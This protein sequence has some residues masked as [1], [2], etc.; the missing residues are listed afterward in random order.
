MAKKNKLVIL[1]TGVVFEYLKGNEKVR[2]EIFEAIGVENAFVSTISILETYYGM[3]KKEQKDTKSFFQQINHFSID[4]ETCQEAI[5]LMLEY[6]N[7]KIGLPD[8][9]IAA[10][11]LTNQAQLFTYN[12]Q[13]FNYIKGLTLYK[14]KN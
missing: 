1:D 4:K 3:L 12:K 5:G 10:T 13:D 9:L 7:D 11:C 8:C 14:P 6:R 2:V